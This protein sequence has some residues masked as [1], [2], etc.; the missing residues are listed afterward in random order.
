MKHINLD[1]ITNKQL[2]VIL[3]FLI[4]YWYNKKGGWRRVEFFEQPGQDGN[5]AAATKIFQV[6]VQSP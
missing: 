1:L 4:L 3:W 6:V 2:I 5:V